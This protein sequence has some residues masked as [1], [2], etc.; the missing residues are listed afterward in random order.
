MR[1]LRCFQ[2]LANSLA[3][4]SPHTYPAW[5]CLITLHHGR[6]RS[7]VR[8][9]KPSSSQRR[10]QTTL[11]ISQYLAAIVSLLLS[12]LS[13]ADDRLEALVRGTDVTPAI[14]GLQIAVIEEG[15]VARQFAM[16]FVGGPD[17]RPTRINHN[18]KVRV[19]SISKLVVAVGVMRLVKQ[20]KVSLD[21]DVSDYL[22]WRLR[23][24]N[25]PAQQI[26]LRQLLSHTSS[27]RDA[28]EYFIPAGNG[29]LRDFFNP[30]STLWKA[31][32]HWAAQDE[33]P[34]VYFEYAN[35]NFGVIAEVMERVSTQRF[36][37]FMREEVL[38][39]LELAADFNACE[40][41]REELGGALSKR[42]EG[43]QWR[44]KRSW[45][46][47]VDGPHR[48]CFYG[49]VMFDDPAAFL[50]DYELGS[51]A[52]L[53]SPQGGLRASAIDL[54]TIVQLLINKGSFN[55]KPL[56]TPTSIEELLGPVWELSSTVQNGLSAGEA[57]PG[58]DADGLM[59][60]YGL[61][62]H[63]IDMRA[64]G[65][66]KGPRYLLGHLGQAYGV[67]SHAL[68][69]PVSGDGIVTIVGGTSDK[70]DTNAGHSP[71]YR[72][73]EALLHWWINHRESNGN[74][75]AAAKIKAFPVD[76]PF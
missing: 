26:T 70:P 47:Q 7:R 44:P 58:G 6:R 61:S 15:V 74:E 50:A 35:L 2:V 12:S 10:S 39:P 54:A 66:E 23:N 68:F 65:F 49:D 27:I 53:F 43:Y 31:G 73:E 64:W 36:D 18:H 37:Q 42:F 45:V 19:A 69:D 32:A 62:V 46:T 51:N 30:D 56:L 14:S 60:S 16:G 59:T 38:R 33:A 1:W 55:G 5:R 72:I 22:G 17:G 3:P 28:G 40:V 48:V 25:Y 75:A 63:R 24:P 57:E 11:R 71:L 67:L 52:T 13:S 8:E 41:P 34:G 76:R 4:S 21:A 9:G 29:E 20:E